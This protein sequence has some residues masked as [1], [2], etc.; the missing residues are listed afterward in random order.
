MT[1]VSESIDV[2]VAES[3]ILPLFTDLETLPRM[4]SFIDE[5]EPLTADVARWTLSFMGKRKTVDVR[6]V[7]AGPDGV[8]WT[9]ATPG[10]P[11]DVRARTQALG[12]EDTRV[13]IDVEF[14]AGGM[15]EKLGLARPI[16]SKAI[17]NELQNAKAY[18][19]RR[20]VR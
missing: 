17:Q 5:V 20:F 13:T 16:A 11:F 6:L 8:V 7:S 14:D 1:H 18:V 19:E 3:K 10:Q 15:A 9:S 4:L 2:I 12:P